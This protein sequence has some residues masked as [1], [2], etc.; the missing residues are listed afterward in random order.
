MPKWTC[1]QT[2]S[3]ILLTIPFSLPAIS[4]HLPSFVNSAAQTSLISGPL[5]FRFHSFV[6]GTLD[7]TFHLEL[8]KTSGLPPSSLIPSILHIT[9]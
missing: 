3:F 8:Q 1:F 5:P 9:A 7:G 4:R 2:K 6:V